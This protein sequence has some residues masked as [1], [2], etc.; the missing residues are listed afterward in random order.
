MQ[1]RIKDAKTGKVLIGAHIQ[2]ISS[3]K[4]QVS[5]QDGRFRMQAL[6]GD[7]LVISF[8]GFQTL[9]WEVE[10]KWFEN[11]TEFELVADTI[12]LD[13][14]V[15]GL[16]PDYARFKQLL[17]ETEPED[18][19]EVYG[20][21]S[22]PTFAP[23]ARYAPIQ[24]PDI[25]LAVGF[26]FNPESLTKKGKEKRKMKEV[27]ERSSLIEKSWKK[28]NRDW[29]AEMTQLEGDELTSFIVFC[30]FSPEYIVETPLF[31][32]H[33]KMMALLEDFRD[34]DSECWCTTSWKNDP[35]PIFLS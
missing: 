23:S 12:H 17:L 27:L 29:V 11:E 16:F 34:E 14:V 9:G 8:T 24:H 13:E 2:N 26:R 28:F 25:V 3:N 18:T 15:I 1:G 19:F 33:E 7:T 32:I 35:P 30:E 21:S 5:D 4:L 22:L 20:M 31:L 10:E 6:E